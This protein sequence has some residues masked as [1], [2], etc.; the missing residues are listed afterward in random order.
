MR[1]QVIRGVPFDTADVGRGGDG[2]PF[3]REMGSFVGFLVA[4][5]SNLGI[6]DDVD[7]M[8]EYPEDFL[9]DIHDLVAPDVVG[10]RRVHL[11]DELRGPGVFRLGW[12]SKVSKDVPRPDFILSW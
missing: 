8:E 7:V 3:L 1:G 5:V 2:R 9:G 10:S 11:S 12:I 4:G 6:G